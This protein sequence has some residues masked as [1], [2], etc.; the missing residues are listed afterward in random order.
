[1]ND[2][3]VSQPI[4]QLVAISGSS[5]YRRE[6]WTDVDRMTFRHTYTVHCTKFTQEELT[7]H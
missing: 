6:H 3:S 1:M 4:N 2:Q 5:Q 7:Q